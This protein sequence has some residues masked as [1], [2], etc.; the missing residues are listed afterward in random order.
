MGT[1]SANSAHFQYLVKWY[2]DEQLD[3]QANGEETDASRASLCQWSACR[4]QF[5]LTGN[6][7]RSSVVGVDI[8]NLVVFIIAFP[9]A[10]HDETAVHICNEGGGLYSNAVLSR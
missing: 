10:T 2:R 3:K 4:E 7:G 9:D 1:R 5:C 8:I 6:T